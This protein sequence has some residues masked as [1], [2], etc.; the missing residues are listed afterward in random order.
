MKLCDIFTVMG[1]YLD[2]LVDASESRK[3][4]ANRIYTFLNAFLDDADD[5]ANP[6]YSKKDDFLRKVYRGAEHLPVE[7]A[8]FYLSHLSSMAFE[9]FISP[10]EDSVIQNMVDELAKYDEYLSVADFAEEFTEL[11]RRV[12]SNIVDFPE[13]KSIRYADFTGDGKV[14][15]GNSTLNLAPELAVPDKAQTSEAKYIDALLEVYEQD[16]GVEIKTLDDLSKLHKRYQTHFKVQRSYYFSALSAL[17]Q[18]RDIFADS[19]KEFEAL[20]KETLEGIQDTLLKPHK[21]GMDRLDDTLKVV[22]FIHYGKACL[23]RENNGLIGAGEKKGIIH[24]LVNDGKVQW[25]VDYDTD[26]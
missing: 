17:R 18:V 21:N 13:S 19:L 14:R 16:A 1:T 4:K 3:T 11:L 26:I 10:V 6:I 24:M 7:C 22:T 25:V 5:G 8:Q 9:D 23:G 15:V 12:L 2:Q 20:K